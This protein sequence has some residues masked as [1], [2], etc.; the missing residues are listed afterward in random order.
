MAG[1]AGSTLTDEL[2]RLA[3][4]GL[5]YPA[6]TSYLDEKGAAN[7][8]AGTTGME[9]AGALNQKKQP[10]RTKDNYKDLVGICNELAGTPT[11]TDAV[12][13]LRSMT[14]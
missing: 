9:V 3:N 8:W 4:G 11:T 7:K 14:L 13:A 12:T 6:L 1:Q 5:T 2:N 10:G